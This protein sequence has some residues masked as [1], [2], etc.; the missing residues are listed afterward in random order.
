MKLTLTIPI[1]AG[2]LS[3][4]GCATLFSTDA[5][6]KD[7]EAIVDPYL[8]GTWTNEG[9]TLVVRLDGRVYDV[10]YL[11]RGNEPVRFTGRMTRIG[12]ALLLD[13][14][15]VTDDPFVMPLHFAVRVWPEDRT[16]RW[17]MVDGEWAKEQA[18]SLGARREGERTI[19]TGDV[20]R[21]FAGYERALGKVET[22][23]RER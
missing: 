18:A 8:A 16:L 22:W 13:L 9:D 1:L 17:T 10:T 20:L 3:M 5:F 23:V 15:R 2:L 6:V 14:A 21:R 12:E 4:T 19:V 11:D 7:E